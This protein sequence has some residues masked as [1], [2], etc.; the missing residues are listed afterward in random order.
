LRRAAGRGAAEAREPA[1]RL[2]VLL[3]LV[4]LRPREATRGDRGVE[5]VGESALECVV[6][7]LRRDVQALCGVGEKRLTLVVVGTVRRRIRAARSGQDSDP[8]DADRNLALEHRP[9][10]SSFL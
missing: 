1:V 10:G 3:D 9:H 4:G 7:L 6:E 8:G 2:E 5:T